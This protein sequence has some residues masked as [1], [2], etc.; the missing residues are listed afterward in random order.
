MTRLVIIGH[1]G[2]FIVREVTS[3]PR[4][5]YRHFQQ[6]AALHSPLPLMK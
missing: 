4:G 1:L 6:T 3:V 2:M 5:K